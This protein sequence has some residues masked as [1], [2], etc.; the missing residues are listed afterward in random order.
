[1]IIIQYHNT[2]E[3]TVAEEQHKIE[4]SVKT[5]GTGRGE[6][7]LS[8]QLNLQIWNLS[9]LANGLDDDICL[10]LMEALSRVK[11]LWPADFFPLPP[12]DSDI[13]T[14]TSTVIPCIDDNSSFHL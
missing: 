14:Y 5:E 13:D 9:T 1:M 4:N 11:P 12:Q 10:H 6:F 8:S 7:N 3:V 2:A